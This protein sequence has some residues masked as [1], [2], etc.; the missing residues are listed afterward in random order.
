M[1]KINPYDDLFILN[2]MKDSKFVEV[3]IDQ[4]LI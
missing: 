3:D 4:K 2:L 1:K